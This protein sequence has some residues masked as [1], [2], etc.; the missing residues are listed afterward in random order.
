[1]DVIDIISFIG[2]IIITLIIISVLLF[3]S[4][5]L[6]YSKVWDEYYELFGQD[7]YEEES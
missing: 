3:I 6:Q 7:L 4:E 5:I 1:M 2:G